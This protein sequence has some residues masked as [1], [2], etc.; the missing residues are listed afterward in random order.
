MQRRALALLKIAGMQPLDDWQKMTAAEVV[1]N[2]RVG[3]GAPQ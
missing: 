1:D 2:R 3:L